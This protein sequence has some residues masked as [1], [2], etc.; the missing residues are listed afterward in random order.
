MLSSSVSSLF[1]FGSN[2]DAE[3]PLL[4]T[5]RMTGPN[6]PYQLQAISAGSARRKHSVQG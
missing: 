5:G 6:R 1:P 4:E 2:A 3:M